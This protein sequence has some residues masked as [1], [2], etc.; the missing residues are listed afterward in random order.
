MGRVISASEDDFPEVV[1][2]IREAQKKWAR[3]SQILGW[4]GVDVKT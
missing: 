1:E 3:I 2:N 4:E